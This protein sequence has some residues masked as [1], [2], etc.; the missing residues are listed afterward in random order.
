MGAK[1]IDFKFSAGIKENIDSIV[2]YLMKYLSKTVISDIIGNPAMVRFHSL[3][4]ET[5]GRMISSSRYISYIMKKI[6]VS[7]LQIDYILLEGR[8]LY[9]RSTSKAVPCKYQNINK[10]RYKY[11]LLP[12]EIK[13]KIERNLPF[14]PFADNQQRDTKTGK[15]KFLPLKKSFLNFASW[16]DRFT[17][18][19]C[20][21]KYILPLGVNNAL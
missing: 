4:F 17:F 11:E 16:F 3:F 13:P 7:S 5:H 2:N 9:N 8:E 21:L 19:F 15:R 18:I 14:V 1:D 20:E 6:K 12:F 10:V